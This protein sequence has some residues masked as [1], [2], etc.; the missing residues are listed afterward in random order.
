MVDNE[1]HLF[2]SG[3]GGSLAEVRRKWRRLVRKCLK[4]LG[5]SLWRKCGSSI[6]KS[7]KT[8]RRFGGSLTLH[9]K[10]WVEPTPGWLGVGL[11]KLAPTQ[12]E[13]EAGR[14]GR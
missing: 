7:L 14:V 6:A 4:S 2:R 11:R 5:G 9:P 12:C 8:K 13:I 3:F 1:K 10:G